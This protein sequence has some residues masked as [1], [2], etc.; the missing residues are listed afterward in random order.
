MDKGDRDQ[1]ADRLHA[2]SRPFDRI[3]LRSA[4]CDPLPAGVEYLLE[5]CGNLALRGFLT[6]A[7]RNLG[8]GQL[9]RLAD[10]VRTRILGNR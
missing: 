6:G 2:E 7:V 5:R 9:Q 10:L 1:R 8:E 3:D 4:A